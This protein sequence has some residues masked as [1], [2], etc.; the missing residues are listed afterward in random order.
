MEDLP[1]PYSIIPFFSNLFT[2]AEPGIIISAIVLLLLLLLLSGLLSGSGVAFFALSGGQTDQL[3][4]SSTSNGRNAV[5]LIENPGILKATL[6]IANVL[7]NVA[8]AVW[9]TLLFL[10]FFTKNFHPLFGFI[11]LFLI[12]SLIILIFGELLPRRY[13]SRRPLSLVFLMATPLFML[14]KFFF[15]LSRLLEKLSV[16]TDLRAWQYDS[17]NHINNLKEVFD[18]PV[19]R[20]ATEED[21]NILR[22]IVRFGNISAREIMRP[23][24][25]VTAV[26]ISTP[27]STLLPVIV[28]AGYSRVPVFRESFDN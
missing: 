16:Q 13:A 7:V 23:R 6:T 9:L 11:F 12:I 26:E 1:D 27:F 21:R 14:R 15:P 28:E 20:V 8:L 25:D 4:K 10:E 17:N 3:K 24:V 19:Q 22:G 18:H 5:N 2:G